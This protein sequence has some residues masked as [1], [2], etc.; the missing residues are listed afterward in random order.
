[1][2]L[3]NCPVCDSNNLRFYQEGLARQDDDSFWFV[4]DTLH[5]IECNECGHEVSG[6]TDEEAE[7]EW[8]KGEVSDWEI[9][10][11]QRLCGISKNL[12][13]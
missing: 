7:E 13:V 10:S 8:N 9:R 4:E 1:M 11:W 12:S 5:V 2:T 6:Q 3:R